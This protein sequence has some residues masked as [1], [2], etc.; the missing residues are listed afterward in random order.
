MDERQAAVMTANL[1][2]F[3]AAAMFLAAQATLPH[4]ALDTGGDAWRHAMDT[5]APTCRARFAN[6]GSY[7]DQLGQTLS[8]ADGENLIQYD[9]PECGR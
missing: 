9:A 5:P 8:E 1:V 3:A 4:R 2:F 6:S 7:L